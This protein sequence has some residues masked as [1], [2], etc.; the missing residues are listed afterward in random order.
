MDIIY[1]NLNTNTFIYLKSVFHHIKT[2][3]VVLWFGGLSYNVYYSAIQLNA[4]VK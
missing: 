1:F 2:P 4:F 3:E